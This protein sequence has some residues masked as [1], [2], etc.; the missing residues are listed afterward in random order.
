MVIRQLSYCGSVG[1]E[2]L[3]TMV[4]FLLKFKAH[5]ENIQEIRFDN[6]RI[7]WCID[8]KVNLKLLAQ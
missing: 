5:L 1:E 8:L 7:R 4:L 2:I 6:S 3:E